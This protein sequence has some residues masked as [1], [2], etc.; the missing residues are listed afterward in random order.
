MKAMLLRA[1]TVVA[2]LLMA[3]VASANVINIATVH[4]GDVGNAADSTGY[5]QVNYAYNI[6]KFEVT[7][8]Q[9]TAFL[10]AVAKTDTYGL[11][12]P[13]MN[14][15]SY[16]S[17]ITRNGGLTEGDFTYTVGSVWAN[18]PVNYVSFWDACR[19]ANWLQNGQPTGAQG[20]GTTETGAY[21]LTPDGI[22]TN[23]IARNAGAT[24]AVTNENEW[25]KAAYYDPNKYGIGLAG[26]WKYPTK[27][28]TA[29]GRDMNDP[30]PGNNANYYYFGSGTYPIDRDDGRFTTLVGQF[31]DS[32]SP[33]GT[34]DQGGN[35]SEWNEATVIGS[36]G[37]SYR[38]WRGGSF[39][40]DANDLLASHRSYDLP[41]SEFNTIGFRVVELI[42]AESPTVPVPS[43]ALAGMI[44][45][46]VMGVSRCC[47]R[48][49]ARA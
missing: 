23:T 4:V 49:H 16:G 26:Y 20:P 44:L 48:K 39:R 46:G 33:Y 7:A 47:R 34:F 32:A 10:N 8:G 42:P 28:D 22:T 27:S 31:Q 19:F 14:N 2:M 36:N 37:L 40:S 21:T 29:P 18:L 43:A 6:G 17:G 5:G 12:N 1:A 9:Y 30:Y 25:Y 15:A 38:S 13:G 24:W 11:W 35:V 45:L 3:S 41:T